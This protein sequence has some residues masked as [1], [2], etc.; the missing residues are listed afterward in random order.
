[1]NR[2]KKVRGSATLKTLAFLLAL[3]LAV[4]VCVSGC[5]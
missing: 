3:V 2:P 4:G 1:M 5:V